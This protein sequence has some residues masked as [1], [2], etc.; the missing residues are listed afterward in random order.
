V[1]ILKAKDIM[2]LRELGRRVIPETD[3]TPHGTEKMRQRIRITRKGFRP[4]LAIFEYDVT[5]CECGMLPV[6]RHEIVVGGKTHECPG[7]HKIYT[8]MQDEV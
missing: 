7:C 5:L 2:T 1:E 4:V 8:P 3:P 6:P